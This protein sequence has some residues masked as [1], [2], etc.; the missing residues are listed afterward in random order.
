[1]ANL[2]LTTT[3]S[4]QTTCTYCFAKKEMDG[5]KDDFL[6][7]DNLIYI[8]DLLE[9]SRQPHISLLGGEPTLHPS[10]IDFVLYLTERNIRV[11]VFTNGI[12]ANK[13]IEEAGRLF[14]KL[15]DNKLSFVC[16]LNHPSF[17]SEKELDKIDKFLKT[18]G[19]LTTISFNIYQPEFSMDYIFEYINK[20]NMKRH[21]R[22]GLTHNILNADNI[23]IKK[24]EM[25]KMAETFMN[26]YKLFEEN[27][28]TA[29]F[30][31]GMPMCLFNDEQ[32]GK[33][34]KISKGVLKFSCGPAIDIGPDMNVWSCFPFSNFQKKSIYDFNTMEEINKHFKNMHNQIR[35]QR[36]GIFEECKDCSY[37]AKNLCSGGCSVHVL[38]EINA[39]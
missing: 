17:S 13:K 9:I 34:F 4:R 6:T 12:A 8:T 23:Y 3:C 38:N 35:E 39:Q 27:N 25:P 33:L 20:Y 14:D 29:G 26:H 2:L 19:H 1:M 7:W 15:Q 16:N 28:V 18:F 24:E 37:L 31:C 32:L 30:D 10:F 36:A 22:I 21:V 11:N 5:G